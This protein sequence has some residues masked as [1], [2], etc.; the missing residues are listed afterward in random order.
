MPDPPANRSHLPELDHVDFLP[1]FDAFDEGI[2]VTDTDGRIL[3][4]GGDMLRRSQWEL[5]Q[6]RGDKIAMVYQDPMW[7]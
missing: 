5:N 1:V 3:F 6:I 2:I 4:G 7:R